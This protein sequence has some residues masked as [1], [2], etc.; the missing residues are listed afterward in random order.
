LAEG[1][2]AERFTADIRQRELSHMRGAKGPRKKARHTNVTP[3]RRLRG[4]IPD[5]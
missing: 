2:N 4:D 3:I 5:A 1:R